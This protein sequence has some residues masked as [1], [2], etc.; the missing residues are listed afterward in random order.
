MDY[1]LS[2]HALFELRRRAIEEKTVREIMASPEQA[3]EVRPGR[4][5]LQSRIRT[6]S[7]PQLYLVRVFVDVDRQP[8][9]E[10]TVYR[11]SRIDGHGR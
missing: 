10:V 6:G 1:I 4:A 9:E 7:P 5:V 2:E 3:F 8:A 11:T